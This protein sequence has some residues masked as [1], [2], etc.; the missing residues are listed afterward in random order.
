MHRNELKKLL[1]EYQPYLVDEIHMYQNMCT[2][3]DTNPNCFERS[4]LPGHFTASVWIVNPDFNKVLM[5]HH[6]KIGLWLQ[7]GGHC[8]GDSRVQ[9]VAKKELIEETGLVDF[10]FINT[11][12]DVDVHEISAYKNDPSHLHYDVRFL[13]IANSQQA[14]ILSD[15]SNSIEWFTLDEA[16]KHNP[17]RSIERMVYKTM[18][19]H[20]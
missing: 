7:P 15:E 13:A 18:V 2:F 10:S 1:E 17:H 6:K 4:C 11:I 5:V 12:F 3:L 16:Y 20:K 19:K 8:D 14:T 9:E